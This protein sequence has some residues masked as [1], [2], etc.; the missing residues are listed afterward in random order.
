MVSVLVRLKKCESVGN[1]FVALED[2]V[3]L[4]SVMKRYVMNN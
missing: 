2:L 3:N 1:P 4:L